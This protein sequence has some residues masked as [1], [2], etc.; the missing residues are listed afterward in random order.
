MNGY[1]IR[2][3]H[4]DIYKT[5]TDGYVLEYTNGL[6]KNRNSKSRK[7]WQI[8]GAWYSIGFGHIKDISLGVL[9]ENGDN[10]T[11]NN[12]KPRFGL[13]DIDHGTRRWCGNKEYHGV[14]NIS[15]Y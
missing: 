15:T 10:L 9:L 6:K 8:V 4:S 2:T 3:A 12:G 13:I 7:T 1:K 5:D 11:L 14:I